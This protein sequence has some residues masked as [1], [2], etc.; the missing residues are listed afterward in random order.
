MR[1]VIR[2]PVELRQTVQ[3]AI[4]EAS[5]C[6]SNVYGAGTFDSTAAIA[7]AERLITAIAKLY[8]QEAK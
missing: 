5:M 8:E 4:G 6:W 3:E 7:I 2:I 1:P